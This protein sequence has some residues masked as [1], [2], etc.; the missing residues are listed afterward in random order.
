L[1]VQNI[2]LAQFR[3]NL[4]SLV[5]FLRHLDPPWKSLT[6]RGTIFHGEE[7]HK[8]LKSGMNFGSLEN[9]KENYLN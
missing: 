4:L 6:S 2:N 8:R 3:R 1:A 9:A 5:T 7:Q